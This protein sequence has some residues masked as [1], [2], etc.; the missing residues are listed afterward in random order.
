MSVVLITGASRGIGAA[1]ALAFAREGYDVAINYCRSEEKANQLV[2]EIKALGARAFAVCAD[3]GDSAQVKEMFE[4]VRRELGS[5]DVL[6]NN[7]GI[8]HTGL[9]TDLTD[10]EW[11]RLIDTDLSGTFYCCREALKD[12]ILAH[13]GAIVNIASM[14][15]EV[16]AS[17]EAA[18]SAA[19][20]GV[21]GLTKAL[22]KE[23][24][25]SGICINAVS[26]GVIMTDMMAEYTD[27]DL[28]ALKEETP[29][30]ALGTPGDIADAVVFLA[31]TK[32]KFITGQVLGVNG[33][34][35]I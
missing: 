35:V 22:A 2:T 33:G 3:V 29:L 8:A 11:K 4:A 13:S 27:D 19:K 7:A 25:P 14:W 1:C 10:D 24:G 15:G 6:V 32:A 28:A 9:L 26:P 30:N 23:V 12:M 20:A 5:V 16:G 34:I 17:C 18:Y 21:I 31:S